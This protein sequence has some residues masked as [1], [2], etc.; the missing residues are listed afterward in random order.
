MAANFIHPKA[1]VEST[2]IGPGTKVWAFAHVLSGARIGA[3]CNICDGVFIENDVALGDR[4][5]VKCGVQLWDGVT[6]EDDVFIGPNATFTNDRFPRSRERPAEFARTR[7]RRG[8]SIGANATLLPGVTVGERAMVGAGA[9]V[10]KNVPPYAVVV[11]NPARISGYVEAP[12]HSAGAVSRSLPP[13]TGFATTS[14]R[15]VQIHRLPQAGDLRGML[16]FGEFENQ[17]PFPVKRF[18]F[19][20]DVA[21]KDVRGEHAH[22]EN[23]QFL[24]CAHGTVHAMFDDGEHREEV[25]LDTPHVGLYMPPMIWGTQYRYDRETVLLVFASHLYDPDDYI[26]EYDAFIAALN[27]AGR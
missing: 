21:S 6:I 15:G 9:V 24:I 8:A 20:Y 1:I 13:Q 18:F 11:G 5:T 7:I 25:V 22:R 17:V 10:T 16:S 26:R 12:K 3:D 4:V 27:K 2:Q 19:I 23:H 14:V